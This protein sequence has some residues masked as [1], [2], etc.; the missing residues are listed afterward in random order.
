MLE[1]QGVLGEVDRA[2]DRV[3]DG[4]EA[5]LDVTPL[6]GDEHVGDRRQRHQLCGGEVGLGEQGLLGERPEGAEKSHSYQRAVVMGHE[7]PG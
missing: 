7:L 2:L 4:D 6:D 1:C 5:E 3:L